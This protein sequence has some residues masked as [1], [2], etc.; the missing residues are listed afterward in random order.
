MVETFLS[1]LYA[2]ES[3]LCEAGLCNP[4]YE[5]SRDD[6]KVLMFVIVF[7]Q[8]RKGRFGDLGIWGDS[9]GWIGIVPTTAGIEALRKLNH[10]LSNANLC[11]YGVSTC[12]L[13][14]TPQSC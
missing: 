8:W 13:E 1:T 5:G 12:R 9:N 10:R 4:V 6:R 2:C 3:I 7:D 11:D 14:L